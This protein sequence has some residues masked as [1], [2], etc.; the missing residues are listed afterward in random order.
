MKLIF[1][2][3]IL[4]CGLSVIMGA[5]GAHA[6]KGKLSEYSMDI[7]NK[8]VLYQMFHSTAVIFVVILNQLFNTTQFNICG[9]IFIIG[10]VLFSGSLFLLSITDIKLLG[11]VT[12]IGGVL[13]IIGWAILFYLVFKLEI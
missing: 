3:G 5:F 1:L 6:L 7:F 9:W 10:I 12:P 2:L 11:A 4:L 8:A 13:F